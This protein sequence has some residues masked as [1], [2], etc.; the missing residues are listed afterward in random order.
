MDT[1]RTYIGTLAI[2]S[3]CTVAASGLLLAYEAHA[4]VQISN[5]IDISASSGADGQDGADGRDGR[6]GQDGRDG[7]D[8]RSRIEAKSDS[9]KS[10]VRVHTVVNG[11]VVESYEKTSTDD[12]EYENTYIGKDGETTTSVEVRA[13]AG[14]AQ[15][16]AARSRATSE[17]GEAEAD[18][19]HGDSS[20]TGNDTEMRAE[21][22]ATSSASSTPSGF[23]RTAT[24]TERTASFMTQVMSAL[25]A[26]ITRVFEYVFGWLS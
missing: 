11:K 12:I 1:K 26:S 5:R 24:N 25:Q 8:A 4:D 9:G 21:S 14:A 2:I 16:E 17:A 19:Q 23:E 20:A 6:D 22:A 7:I 3:V 13:N 18:A 15:S 10:S